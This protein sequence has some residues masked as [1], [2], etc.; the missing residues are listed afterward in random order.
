MLQQMV[1]Q[2]RRLPP[3][4][5]L[6]RALGNPVQQAQGGCLFHVVLRP[7]WADVTG[8]IAKDAQDDGHGL[9][10]GHRV[11]RAEGAVAV[12]LHQSLSIGQVDV[13]QRPV[14]GAY[15]GEQRAVGAAFQ[16]VGVVLGEHRQ[17]AE[18]TAGQGVAWV[19]F[20]VAV[21]ADN[22]H[23]AQHAHRLGNRAV[24]HIAERRGSGQQ[25]GAKDAQAQSRRQQHG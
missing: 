15:I 8:G 13:G 5:A 19:I 18:L 23:A 12:A 3:V 9:T 4:Q 21:A 20:S 24:G 11:L 16:L 17:L 25:K 7:E 1:E 6:L 2:Q 10:A 14:T 22:A